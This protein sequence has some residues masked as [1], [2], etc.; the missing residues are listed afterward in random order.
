VFF[1]IN[2]G[3][4]FQGPLQ[5]GIT[6]GG[7]RGERGLQFVHTDTTGSHIGGHHDGALAL[8]EFVENPVTLL[9]LLVTVNGWKGE[10]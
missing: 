4:W 10:C 7:G 9:L 2:T 8:L 1:N 3:E 5:E 6:I